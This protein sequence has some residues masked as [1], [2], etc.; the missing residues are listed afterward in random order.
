MFLCFLVPSLTFAA[1][2]RKGEEY[3]C[4]CLETGLFN[5]NNTSTAEASLFLSNGSQGRVD[6]QHK[7]QK[8]KTENRN[9]NRNQNRN[10]KRHNN[11]NNN[12]RSKGRLLGSDAPPVLKLEKEIMNINIVRF[13]YRMLLCSLTSIKNEQKKEIKRKKKPVGPELK[14]N[15]Y[16]LYLS[17]N[18][19]IE[20][21]WHLATPRPRYQLHPTP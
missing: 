17:H 8:Q 18:F 5:P 21:V 9:R 10:R 19:H 7:A 6:Y 14:M 2:G 20:P 1:E 3:N 15:R 4:V 13:S 16:N 12:N 11:N